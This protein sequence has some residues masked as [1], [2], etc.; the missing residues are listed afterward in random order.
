[1][2]A[3]LLAGALTGL[4]VTFIIPP[5]LGFGVSNL[6]PMACAV[7]LVYG[8]GAAIFVGL[9]ILA[10]R[11]HEPPP[12]RCLGCGYDL[13]GLPQPRCPECGTAF[14]MSGAGEQEHRA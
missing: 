1:M 6:W 4:C 13:R 11:G 3:S 2:A 10:W 7:W 9:P 14:S 8:F 5:L 12:G